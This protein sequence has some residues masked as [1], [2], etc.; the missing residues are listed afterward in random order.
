MAGGFAILTSYPAFQV[1]L[2][3][4]YFSHTNSMIFIIASNC[5]FFLQ[6]LS[7]TKVTNGCYGVS[8]TPGVHTNVFP[9]RLKLNAPCSRVHPNT[10]ENSERC[11]HYNHRSKVFCHYSHK[12]L[13]QRLPKENFKMVDEGMLSSEQ[14]VTRQYRLIRQCGLNLLNW[15]QSSKGGYRY[16]LDESLFLWM[17]QLASLILILWIGDIDIYSVDGAI[18]RLSDKSF[19]RCGLNTLAFV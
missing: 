1:F 14:F 17:E 7:G 16:P 10:I 15:P 5:S 9:F 19:D 13:F 2:S 3:L 18:Q 12:F 6:E 8:L 11:C 4:K